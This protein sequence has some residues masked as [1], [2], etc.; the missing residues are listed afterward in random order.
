ME[1]LAATPCIFQFQVLAMSL[2]ANKI[3]GRMTSLY[4]TGMLID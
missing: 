4:L 3:T 2:K 1:P